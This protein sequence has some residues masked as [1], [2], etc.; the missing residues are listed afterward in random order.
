MKILVLTNAENDRLTIRNYLS[1]HFVIT[2]NSSFEA[3]RLLNVH[4]DINVV[5]IDMEA[6]PGLHLCKTIRLNKRYRDIIIIFTS[7]KGDMLSKTDGSGTENIFYLDK[8]LSR[9]SLN[10]VVL[11]CSLLL[12]LRQEK[13]RE[14]SGKSIFDVIFEQS[15]IGVAVNQIS[16]SGDVESFTANIAYQQITGRS[17]EELAALDW[18]DIT[19]PDD[20][21]V[22]LLQYERLKKGE[23]GNFA[24]KKRYIRPDGSSVW[25]RI[26]VATVLPVNDKVKYTQICL[27]Q[28]ISK[29]KIAEDA[30]LE[31]ERSKSVLLSHFPGMAYRSRYDEHWTMEF[32][33]QGCYELTGYPSESLLYNMDISFNDLI[34]PEYRNAMRKEWERAL[35]KKKPFKYEYEITTADNERK[36]VLEMGE[37]IF[38]DNGGVIALEGVILDISDRKKIE[39]ELRYNSEHNRWTGLHNKKYFEELLIQESKKPLEEKRAILSINL[40]TLNMLLSAYGFHYV[41]ELII[42]TGNA[43]SALCNE[44]R[45]L[46]H[47]FENSFLFYVKDYKDL[48]DLMNFSDTVLNT[49]ESM[50][51]L[52]RIGGGI[53]IVEIDDCNRH[54]IEHLLKNALI[55]SENAIEMYDGDFGCCLFDLEMEARLIRNEEIR[56]ELVLIASD[57]KDEELFLE[58]QP[59]VCLNNDKIW[60]FEALARIKSNRLGLIRPLEFIP[61]AERTKLIIP[62]GESIIRKALIFLKRLNDLGYSD[63]NMSIN[64][65]AIQLLKLDFIGSFTKIIHEAGVDPTNICIEITES[66]FT[67]NYQDINNVLEAFRVLGVKSAID[68]F[69]TGYSSFARGWE[70]DVDGIKIDK[71]FT[72]KLPEHGSTKE[73]VT[74]DIIS[75]AH[76]LGYFV[77]AEGVEKEMQKQYLKEH[78]CDRMQGYLFSRPL[79]EKA[80]IEML[81]EHR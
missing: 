55:A 8:P 14:S 70:L 11:M 26:M 15:T 52:E 50:L 28:N 53:G 79:S 17:A 71:Y 38:D 46:F 13:S 9:I 19:H 48:G 2:P 57:G 32:M 36:W 78:R 63:L 56:H 37:G 27:V 18:K 73:A 49:L 30:L 20:V 24:L 34:L 12:K 74:G 45:L 16:R 59:V 80:A 35:I 42:Q 39:D 22:E 33:S 47:T 41:Q 6:D 10:T 67:P 76:K 21:K 44:K 72:D 1:S 3:I 58:F 66:A 75:M 5:I 81:E 25:V 54:D 77:V 23:I 62:L 68:D 64:I 60:G 7:D 69:G 40:T 29:Q 4:V 65:S 31:S 61:I 51:S 43:L